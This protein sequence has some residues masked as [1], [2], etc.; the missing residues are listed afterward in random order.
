MTQYIGD[1]LG[2]KP[3]IRLEPSR[4]GEVTH[5]VANVGKARALLD[6][7]PR[8]SLEEGIHKS[9]AWSMEW[10]AK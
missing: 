6:Y 4:V 7:N 3:D 8:V 10:W 1:A 5:Y 2:V 9:V